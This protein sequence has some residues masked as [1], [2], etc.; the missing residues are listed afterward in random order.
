MKPSPAFKQIILSYLEN[1]AQTD[2]LFAPKFEN[3]N[4]N[5]DDCITYIFST[6]HKSGCNGFHHDEIFAMAIH[7]YEEENIQIDKN[8]FNTRVVV[9]QVVELTEEE[10]EEAKES[11]I[12][13]CIQ[14]EYKKLHK[15]P[16]KAAK[17]EKTV[18]T[19]TSLF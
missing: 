14:D 11:A 3:P 16:V 19:Q 10:K 7:Y 1:K 15:A 4:K 6:V 17:E 9:N 8:Q 13:L 18:F 5:I 12:K 2:E